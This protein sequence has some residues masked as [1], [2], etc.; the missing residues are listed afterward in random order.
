MEKAKEIKTLATCKPSEFLRQ[1]NRIRKSVEKWL[2]D[3]EINKIRKRLPEYE[4]IP[5]GISK[6]EAQEVEERN[7]Q[8]KRDQ[9]RKNL[10]EILD[11]VL[12][13]HPDETLEILALCCFIDPEDADNY[14]VNFYLTA[15]TEL[16]SNEAVLGF[17][18][19]LASLG[20]RN[21]LSA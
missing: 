7:K 11:A 3:T 5:A 18:T 4:D 17:F 19:S 6:E 20:Q 2:T 12:D 9:M 10:S 14:E 8:K 21:I 16:I 13:G 1:T 15:F